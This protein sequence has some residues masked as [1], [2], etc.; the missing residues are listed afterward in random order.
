MTK[1]P[2]FAQR[3]R[4]AFDNTLAR[5][6]AALILWLVIATVALIVTAILLDLIVGGVSQ[7]AGL[8]PREVFW[9]ILFQA[10]VPNPPGNFDS[11]VQFLVIMF[12]VTIASLGMVSILIGLA[13]ATIQDRL[14]TLRRGRSHIIENNHTVILGW[15]D[16]VFAIVSELIVAN[17]NQSHSTIAILGDKDKV[18]ME[19]ELRHRIKSTGRTR[20]VVRRRRSNEHAAL[21]L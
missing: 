19:E 4:Y 3:L 10:L 20:I 2:T 17:A 8:G 5:G 13:S 16:Q 12:G 1:K 9:N 7:E 18:E 15:S 6:P 11:P 14:E 21:H